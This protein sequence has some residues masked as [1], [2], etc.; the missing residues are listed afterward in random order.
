MS[1]FREGLLILI[2]YL[3]LVILGLFF[4]CVVC[5]KV[6]YSIKCKHFLPIQKIKINGLDPKEEVKLSGM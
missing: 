6:N 3:I 1:D 4:L 5:K 2:S